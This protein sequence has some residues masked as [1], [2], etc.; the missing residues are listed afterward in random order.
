MALSKMVT[1]WHVEKRGS[2]WGIKKY[3]GVKLTC[4]YFKLQSGLLLRTV[5]GQVGSSPD[6]AIA[7]TIAKLRR[8][9]DRVQADVDSLLAIEVTEP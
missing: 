5:P 4:E 6:E 7:N 9:I 1:I 8:K 2:R 3:R